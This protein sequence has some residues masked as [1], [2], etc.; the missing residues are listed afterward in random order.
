ML[1]IDG[2]EQFAFEAGSD[3]FMRR[4]GYKVNG[5]MSWGA[6]RK[7]GSAAILARQSFS[8]TVTQ[9]GN[10][11]TGVAIKI[12]KRGGLLSVTNGTDTIVLSAEI[13]TGLLKLSWDEDTFDVGYVMPLPNRWYYFELEFDSASN[14]VKTYVNGKLD[15]TLNLPTSFLQPDMT[16]QWRHFTDNDFGSMA[17]DDIY[18]TDNGR[19]G[20]VT[21]TTR[22]PRKDVTAEWQSS[23]DGGQHADIMGI[24]PPD[25][26]ERF[27]FSG[28]AD[29]VDSYNSDFPLSE[30][31]EVK[32]V[33]VV[34]LLRKA[35]VDPVSVEVFLNDKRGTEATLPRDWEYRYTELGVVP[36]HTI[37][38]SVFGVKLKK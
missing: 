24:V 7:N 4:A 10:F 25:L 36:V 27:I 9:G 26:V 30:E 19:I 33:S 6:G 8:R 37:P 34:T 32:G 22:F 1:F 11:A 21:V 16:V 18:I 23:I 17:F 29:A 28:Q 14:R 5:G 31:T 20:P 15:V 35:T 38:D 12:F 2:L 13:D 3:A